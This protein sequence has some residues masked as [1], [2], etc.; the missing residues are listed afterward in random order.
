V[1]Q[2]QRYEVYAYWIG[3]RTG[4]VGPKEIDQPIHF[5]SPVAFGGQPGYWTPEDMLIAAVASCYVATF[6]TMAQLSKFEFVELGISVTGELTQ[7]DE[8][9]K[10]RSIV[11]RPKL[12]IADE[13]NRE[14]AERLLQKAGRGCLVARSLLARVTL[15]PAIHVAELAG[16]R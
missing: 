6:S 11:I 13:T 7:A 15:E 1:N 2:I 4:A 5:S 12:T 10:F 16:V 8:G 9:W 3:A 14:R